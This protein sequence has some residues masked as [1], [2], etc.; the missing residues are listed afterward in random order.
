MS[1]TVR[2]EFDP[3]RHCKEVSKAWIV[4]VEGQP[5]LALPKSRTQL[6]RDGDSVTAVTVPRW[7]A[8]KEELTEPTTCF[9]EEETGDVMTRDDW[10]L[11]GLTMAFVI[12]GEPMPLWEAGKLIQRLREES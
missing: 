6:E 2:V 3:P 4:T 10:F 7:L 9:L 11:L 8:E 5:D 1:E 12:R